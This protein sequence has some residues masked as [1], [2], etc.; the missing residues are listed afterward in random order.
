MKNDAPIDKHACVKCGTCNTVCP[1]FK[2][3]GHEAH[4]ARGKQ[5]LKTHLQEA[6]R[7]PHFA[8]IFSKCL[9]CGACVEACPRGLDTPQMVIAARGELPRLAG[10]SFIKYV[11]RKALIHPSLISGLT[12][13]GSAAKKLMV[14]HLPSESGLRLR[15][16]SF[17]PDILQLPGKSYL[18]QMEETNKEKDKIA[19]AETVEKSVNY[20]VGCFANHLQPEI[21]EKTA[22]L[23][24]RVG[25]G[26][27]VVP[28]NQTC[29]GM[30]ALAAG[31]SDEARGLAKKNIETFAGNDLPI[32][33]SCSSCYY[34]LM[35]YKEL[36]DDDPEWQQRARRFS[37]RLREFS[38]FLHENL[39]EGP[40][41]IPTK[42]NASEHRVFY[43]DP[44]HLRYKLKITREPRKLLKM[45]KTVKL[46]E[47]PNGPQCCGQG[48]L[49]QVAHP[50][51]ALQIRE[52]LLDDFSNLAADTVVTGC[53]GC[54]LQWQLGLT[55][56]GNK[57]QVEHLALLIAKLL[58]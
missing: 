21:A 19:D 33:T 49:F 29:C 10:L 8:D 17:D 41:F 34:Q 26:E 45:F 47:L 35:A 24:S 31:K 50:E 53:S 32:L 6:E 55:A 43:H 16:L 2:V 20:F 38:V 5:H 14:E 13:V 18:D 46:E 51:L 25:K 54:L 1:V 30:A 28:E 39:A 22:S 12:R 15:L 52:R 57:I 9:L 3:T 58:Q 23:V 36:F 40:E 37:E 7:S 27:P 42:E 11:S 48:G 56:G 44:C 4:G